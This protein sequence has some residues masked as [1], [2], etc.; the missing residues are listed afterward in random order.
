M[1][2]MIDGVIVR[3]LSVKTDQRGELAELFRQDELPDSDLP[4]MGYL[5]VSHP[6]VTRGPHEH[7]RQT[8]HFAFVG[9]S[10]FRLY[11]WDNRPASPSFGQRLVVEC[12]ASSPMAILVPPGVVHAYRNVGERDGMVLNFPNRLYAGP[13]RGETPDEIRHENDSHSPFQIED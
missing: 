11:L 10:H 7:R 1:S 9:S 3:K 5:S 2:G 6:G 13:N 12:P 8:D 4:R